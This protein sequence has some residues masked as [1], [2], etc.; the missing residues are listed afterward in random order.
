VNL[1]AA[2]EIMG[3]ASTLPPPPA[4]PDFR[5]L[6]ALDAWNREQNGRYLVEALHK[7]DEEVVALKSSIRLARELLMKG[8]VISAGLVLLRALESK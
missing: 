7:R 8:A 4:V 5:S 6:E 3:E 1:R 2:V